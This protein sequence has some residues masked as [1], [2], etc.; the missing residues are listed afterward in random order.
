MLDTTVNKPRR[1]N[2]QNVSTVVSAA[3]L[4]G[5]FF[6]KALITASVPVP[7]PI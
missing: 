1:V 3:I 5:A 4:I 2:W 7:R 6:T